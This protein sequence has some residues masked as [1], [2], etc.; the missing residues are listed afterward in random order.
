[1]GFVANA[2]RW[3]KET[4]GQ[5]DL[6]DKRLEERLIEYG[7]LQAAAPAASTNQLSGGDAVVAEGLYRFLRNDRVQPDGIAEGAFL[8][9]A[10]LCR[11]RELVLLLEDSTALGYT[12]S[13]AKDLGDIGGP[14]GSKTRGMYVHSALAVDAFNG[15]ILGL[16]DQHRWIRPEQRP[17]REKRNQVPYAEKESFKWQRCS[18]EMARRLGRMEQVISVCDREADIHEYLQYKLGEKQRFVVRG[19]YDRCVH[20]EDAHLFGSVRSWPVMGGWVV[21]TSQRG[22]WKGPK[23]TRAARKARQAHLEVRF[24]RMTIAMSASNK[25]KTPERTELPVYV[26]DVREP[27]PPPGEAP[28]EWFLLTSE[29][30]L[31][32]EDAQRILRFYERRWLIEEFHDAW[33]NGCGVERRRQQ[34]P[35]NL[36][37]LAVIL[38]FI[39]VYI[40]Q[41]RALRDEARKT[42]CDRILS[43]MQ[44]HCLWASR[45]PGKKLPKRAPPIAWATEAVAALGGWRDTKRNGRMGWV[46]LWRGWDK[47]Q[48]RVQGWRLAGELAR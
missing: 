47:L 13:V 5:S 46:S 33:K 28:M 43:E 6:G 3:S 27:H 37:R 18:Q 41:L 38:A 1:M 11:D 29:P 12:H 20:G 35:D 48:E 34:A 26:V 31:T 42:P 44:W 40:L 30:I 14:K 2:R 36:E 7:A 21:A 19:S 45:H 23:G 15:D 8:H 32:L 25:S 24:G 17:G 4:F 10:D 16:L 9:T 39:A 22:A